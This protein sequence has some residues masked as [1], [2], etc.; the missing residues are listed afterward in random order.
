MKNK[1]I[2]SVFLIFGFVNTQA[3]QDAMYTQ[4]MFNTLAIN[5]AY[6]GSR[7]VLSATGLIRSQWV[8]IEGA[9]ETQTVSLDAAMPNKRVGLGIQVFNDKVGIT[10]NS[11]LNLNY[12]YRIPMESGTLAFGILGSIANYRADFMR[13]KLNSG[14]A[15]DDAFG[16]NINKLL[17]NVGTGIYYNT[18]R[19]YLGA[20]IPR[21]LNNRLTNGNDVAGNSTLAASQYRHLFIMAGYVMP[22]GYDLKVKPSILFKSVK[23]APMQLDLNCNLW[24]KDV[25]GV[26]AQY[27]TGDAVAGIL[28]IQASDQIRIG[29]SYDYT[30]SSLADYNSG[31]HEIMLRY[32]F[33]F[34]K[35]RI[36]APRYF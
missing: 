9:P 22:L 4:Y 30:T 15:M 24:I 7:N 3:Q 19:L 1:L 21:L 5:P 26:G 36:V 18:D 20:S 12:A 11:G 8:G 16:N 32:E 2:I 27:R 10:S 34:S 28:E 14:N 33:G 6:A 31:S 17:P 13:V 23:G 29:Y 35:S 25:I